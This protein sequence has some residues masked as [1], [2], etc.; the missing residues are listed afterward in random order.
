VNFGDFAGCSTTNRNFQLLRSK[1]GRIPLL[2][3]TDY[4]TK[5]NDWTFAISLTVN[6][7]VLEALCWW[8]ESIKE[9]TQVK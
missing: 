7:A 1:A 9:T 2:I 3:D 5:N 8:G 6:G 4:F